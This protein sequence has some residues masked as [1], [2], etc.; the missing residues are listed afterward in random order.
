MYNFT[1]AEIL[2]SSPSFSQYH[3]NYHELVKKE[4][5]LRFSNDSSILT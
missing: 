5:Q 1:M 2:V 3:E 4:I